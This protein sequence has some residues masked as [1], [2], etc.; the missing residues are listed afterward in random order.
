M[1]V[2]FSNCQNIEFSSELSEKRLNKTTIVIAVPILRRLLAFALYLLGAKFSD[3][4]NLLGYSVNSLKT[5]FNSLQ[6]DGL[7]ALEDRR[8]KR[9]SKNPTYKQNLKKNGYIKDTKDCLVVK[10]PWSDFLIEIP[11]DNSGQQRAVLLTLKNAGAFSA[12]EVGDALNITSS[13]VRELCK[14]IESED[15]YG[16]IDKRRGQLIDY[17]INS[18][19]KAQ[20]IQQFAMHAVTRKSTSSISLTKELN[21][22]IDIPLSDRTI[23]EHI[24]N[25]GL[26]S[27]SKSLPQLIE[28]LKKNSSQ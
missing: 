28:N 27:I 5:M 4:A 2:I 13:R 25:L 14:K 3:I 17:R 9:D 15:I 12:K 21:K 24:K 10:I 16:I 19:I 26:K 23:R 6:K 18:K 22:E 8:K 1:K 20:L 11:K 7:T